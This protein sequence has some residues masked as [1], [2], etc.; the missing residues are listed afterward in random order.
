MPETVLVV[1]ATGMLGEPTEANALLGAPSTTVRAWS[2]TR[3]AGC[4]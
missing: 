1:G 3:K 2:E 4:R